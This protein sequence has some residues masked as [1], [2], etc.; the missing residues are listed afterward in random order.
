MEDDWVD[1]TACL[2]VNYAVKDDLSRLLPVVAM[3]TVRALFSKNVSRE[4]GDAS[5]EQATIAK[6][7]HNSL[8]E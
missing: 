8:R 6:S 2:T 5:N 4:H 3:P 7:N 1:D